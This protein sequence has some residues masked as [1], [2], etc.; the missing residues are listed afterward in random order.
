MSASILSRST[1][2]LWSRLGPPSS[3]VRLQSS[4]SSSSSSSSGP[5]SAQPAFLNSQAP[6][7]RPTS[8]E[9][10]DRSGKGT[11]EGEWRPIQP[12]P[13]QPRPPRM[14]TGH[15]HRRHNGPGRPDHT[16][17]RGPRDGAQRPPPGAA[18][19][20]GG[21]PPRGGATSSGPDPRSGP[22][23]SRMTNTAERE[24]AQKREHD[25]L[26]RLDPSK[27]E[28]KPHADRLARSAVALGLD[29]NLVGSDLETH[30]ERSRRFKSKGGGGGGGGG[31]GDAGHGN[32][33]GGGP[34]G[35]KEPGTLE[36]WQVKREQEQALLAQRQ[37][38]QAASRPKKVKAKQVLK[39]VE[40][41][42]TL[43]LDNLVN[44]LHERLFAVQRA[45][46]RIG[47]EDVRPDRLLTSEDA[48]LLALE[49][50][51]DPVIDDE[52]GFDLFPLPP[53]PAD[54]VSPR[55]PITGIF[56]HVDHGKTSLLDALRSTSVASGEAGGITQHIGAFEV[57]VESM[58]ANLRS[59]AEGKPAPPAKPIQDGDA[60]ITFLDTPGH[61][62]FTAMRSRGA[63]VTD[64]AVLVVAADDGVKPQTEEVIALLKTAPDVGVVVALTKVD[65]PGV[66]TTRVKHE[67]LAADVAVEELG[68]DV[69]CVEVSS[70]TG[71]GLAE[72][73]ETISALAE[74][75]ELTAE[76]EGRVEGRVI[77]SRVEK[78][79]GNVATVLV[80]RGCLRSTASL[81]AGTT[82]A[83]VRTLL[84][85]SGKSVT[86]AYPGQPVEV[87]G[88]KDLPT[89]GDLVLEAAT[90][91]EAKRAVSNRL[92]RLEQEKMWSE[93][94]IINE[95]QKRD[96]EILA[97]RREEEEKAKAKGLRGNAVIHAGDVA[98]EQLSAGGDQ[99]K[100][101]LLIVKADVSGTVEAVVGALEGIGN[102]EAKVKILT[103]A[104]GPVT[105]ADVDMARTAGAC[106]IGFNV[107]APGSVMK[108]A[109]KGPTP[110]PVH[111]SPIIYRLVETVRNET[112]ALL[113]KN[114]ETRVHGEANVQMVF[115]ISVKGRKE[116][117]KIA[118]SK[119]F[120]GV[121]QKTRKARVI[122]NG[123]TLF[124]GTVS[125]LKQVKKDV[126]EIPKG[127]EC[128]IALDGFGDWQVDDL[129]QSIE[130][131]EVARSL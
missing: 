126:N 105:Q 123:E 18:P 39:K 12:G 7:P 14:Q 107:K 64:V 57:G 34:A 68:G 54:L 76:R 111:T 37:R 88:W 48:S 95:K 5:S 78:G 114:V 17:A 81:V 51:F 61:A 60:T 45:A 86:S 118:G 130:E 13:R 124:T 59:K 72:L 85:P 10:G 73:V 92:R 119:V 128:G 109:A 66:D 98:V 65:K 8:R 99:V 4:S 27:P 46:E 100:E 106:I 35:A 122:R 67:L 117:I 19:R 63:G 22:A 84:P 9:Q 71:Q 77:E 28:W 2:A 103:S 121:F 26:R 55:P 44:I 69:P 50:G 129:I 40:L 24:Y 79:R 101:L 38:Q 131:V 23:G 75:R 62:A 82:W 15:P 1:A 3:L 11:E 97:V 49:L 53:S 32:G 56:G 96:A 120:N 21:R 110:V 70:M 52:A 16:H 113:P 42:S 116:P 31:G 58:V 29:P 90:E 6:R 43:R 102:K 108:D 80:L 30:K 115:D 20:G 112:A 127:V 36:P 25:R 125:T 91:D 94:E 89:A 74:V 41:P 104:V 93:V 83:R 47:L 33:A 87:T